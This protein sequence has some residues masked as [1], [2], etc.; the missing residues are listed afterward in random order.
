[1]LTNCD[2]RYIMF[3]SDPGDNSL[4]HYQGFSP[5]FCLTIVYILLPHF[6]CKIY[7]FRSHGGIL[8]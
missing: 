3:K 2:L 1:M 5:T 6:K 7:F 8:N 4:V